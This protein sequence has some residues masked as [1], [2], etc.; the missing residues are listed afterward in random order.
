MRAPSRAAIWAL[1]L[2]ILIWSGP[3][4]GLITGGVAAPGAAKPLVDE[5]IT[6]T[7]SSGGERI[8]REARYAGRAINEPDRPPKL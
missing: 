4:F 6:T 3:A 1:N 2:F 8:T 7:P 5:A